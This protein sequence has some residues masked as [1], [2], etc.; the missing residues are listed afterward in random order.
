MTAPEQAMRKDVSV[1]VI[2]REYRDSI[3][4]FVTLAALLAWIVASDIRMHEQMTRRIENVSFDVARTGAHIGA[5]TSTVAH[6]MQVSAA[7]YAPMWSFLCL[8]VI[9]TVWML[10]S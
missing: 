6:T 7:E 2:L 9:L 5:V 8:A 4:S 3:M 1:R 10:R